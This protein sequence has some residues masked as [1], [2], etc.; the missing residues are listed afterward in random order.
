MASALIRLDPD[1]VEAIAS[2]VAELLDHRDVEAGPELVD[3]AEL[4][5]RLGM[6]REWVYAHASELG[7]VKLGSGSKPRLRFD[8][9]VAIER[10]HRSAEGKKHEPARRPGRRRNRA[11]RPGAAPLLPIKGSGASRPLA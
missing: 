4:A 5:R 1:A 9:R 2:R 6:E 3:A 10:M 11:P 8:P 7:V